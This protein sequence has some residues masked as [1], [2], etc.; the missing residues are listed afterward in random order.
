MLNTL[1]GRSLCSAIYSCSLY[2][3]LPHNLQSLFSLLSS[4][5]ISYL[6]LSVSPTLLLFHNLSPQLLSLQHNPLQSLF[7]GFAQLIFLCLSRLRQ[8]PS[9]SHLSPLQFFQVVWLCPFLI[10]NNASTWL[11][12]ILLI[13]I[14]SIY[15]IDKQDVVASLNVCLAEMGETPYSKT[16][17]S[18][19]KSYS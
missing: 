2:L 10:I 19:T 8:A 3:S 17:M 5:I 15:G 7:S 16:K 12:Q 13:K 4:L 14:K 6:P 18:R 11:S 1:A 9:V